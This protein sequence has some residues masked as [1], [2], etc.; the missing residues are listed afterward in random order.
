MCH[1]HGDG[2]SYEGNF[3]GV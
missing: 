3:E 1:G 2:G